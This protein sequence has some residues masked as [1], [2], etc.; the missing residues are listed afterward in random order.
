MNFVLSILFSGFAVVLVVLIPW[1]GVWA[2]DLRFFFGVIVPYLAMATFFI[3]IVVRVIDWGRSPVP[4][5]IPTTAGQEWS[6]PW[7][8]RN[9]IDNPKGTGGVIV[10]M[11]FEVLLFR[12]LFRNTSLEYR[13]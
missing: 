13:N 8:K 10:R 3:G 11:I 7:I 4:F 6:F 5:R 1:V 12:S 2:F 9:P